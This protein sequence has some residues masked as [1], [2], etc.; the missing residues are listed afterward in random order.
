MS[1]LRKP[2]VV[3]SALLALVVSALIA[4]SPA[5]EEPAA[6]QPAAKRRHRLPR[7]YTQVVTEEQRAEIYDLQDE[8]AP[9]VEKLEAELAA[10][11]DERDGKIAAVLTPEQQEK[12]AELEAAARAKREGD[13]ASDGGEQPSDSEPAPSTRPRTSRPR[14]TQP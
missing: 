5:Q 13:R 12:V 9:Q 3:S 6:S 11:E 10:L 8:Y 14:S 2:L 7:Y 4:V 1:L